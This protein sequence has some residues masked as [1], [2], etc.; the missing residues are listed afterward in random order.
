MGNPFDYIN[1]ILETKKYLFDT[2]DAEKDY[3]PFLTNRAL[4]LHIDSILYSNE[5][6]QHGSL[7]KL[8]QYDYYFHSIRK[9]KRKFAKW[10]KKAKDE[11]IDKICEYYSVNKNRAE[12]YA[13][14]LTEDQIEQLYAWTEKGGTKNDKA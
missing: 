6:N 12:E 1:S 5:L 4:S 10:P 3:S 7:D 9:M 13:R 14:M 8:L 2:E 11:D